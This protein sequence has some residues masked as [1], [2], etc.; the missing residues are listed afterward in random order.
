MSLEEAI[1]RRNE[2]IQN[3]RLVCAE[4]FEKSPNISFEIGCGK[5]H[6]LSSYAAENPN[7]ICV[8]IDIISERVRDSQRRAKNKNADNAFF[9]KAEANEF[10]EAMPRD[11]RLDKIFIFFPDPWP[12]KKHHKHRLMQHP[13]LDYIRQ[14]AKSGT[15][16]YFR[17]DHKEYFEWTTEVLN[18]NSNWE[19]TDETELPIEVVSQFQ[20]ILPDFSTL[21]ARAI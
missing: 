4:L 15:K 6:W 13:F 3:L 9:Y 7:E 10:L 1:Q 19:I 17:T 5:G 16:L 20:R 2:R 21:V 18:E 14:F 11:M 8:G 12:K